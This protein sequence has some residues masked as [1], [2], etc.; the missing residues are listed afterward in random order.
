AGHAILGPSTPTRGRRD[1]TGGPAQ[2]ARALRRADQ[3]QCPRRRLRREPELDQVLALLRLHRIPG[4]QSAEIP[5]GNPPEAGG[6]QRATKRPAGGDP[7]IVRN[8][9][10][11]HGKL[12]SS[13]NRG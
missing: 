6:P 12:M 1:R 3:P 7:S 2:S 11:I 13:F 4:E 10:P 5:D 9:L 8:S